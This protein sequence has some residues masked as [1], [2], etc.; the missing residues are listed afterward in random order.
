MLNFGMNLLNRKPSYQLGIPMIKFINQ[1]TKMLTFLIRILQRTKMLNT[2]LTSTEETPPVVCQ[3]A[4]PGWAIWFSPYSFCSCF[5]TCSKHSARLT[6]S[7]SYRQ[8]L[9]LAE[10]GTEMLT[11][12]ETTRGSIEEESLST[13]ITIVIV[14]SHILSSQRTDKVWRALTTVLVAKMTAKS[15][16][17]WPIASKT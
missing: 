17:Q 16:S 5:S 14:D 7:S 11:M 1:A 9:T 13:M 12:E 3:L 2:I 4:P 6:C 10:E 15:E 8:Y